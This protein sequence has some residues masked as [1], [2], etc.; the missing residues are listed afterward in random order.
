[1]IKAYVLGS[2]N[3]DFAY[4]VKRLPKIGETLKA[5]SLKTSTGGK[6]AN[7]AV[8]IARNDIETTLI[9][10]VGED[11]EDIIKELDGYGLN[12][13][14]IKKI[15]NKPT[16]SATILLTESSNSIVTDCGANSSV[17]ILDIVDALEDA[18][19]GDYFICQLE[20]NVEIV[21]F[22]LKLAK[23][24]GLVTF[25]NPSPAHDLPTSM[26]KYVDYL[27]LNEVEVEQLSLEKPFTDIGINNIYNFFTGYGVKNI[28]ITLGSEGAW[29]L[30]GED[31]YT[32]PAKD[33]FVIDTT[34]AGDAF[35]GGFVAALAN[36]IPLQESIVYANYAA[37]L[38]CQV[39]GALDSMPKK[40]YI[41]GLINKDRMQ[42]EKIELAR[43]TLKH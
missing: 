37:A 40:A 32:M 13:N 18:I 16:G 42:D 3:K 30:D 27:I 17:G 24:K 11:D 7:Q 22:G 33:T 39:E 35:L 15:R 34:G 12:T 1:M 10:C 29:Y 6:G 26:Y 14:F 9:A 2:I 28:I 21:K 38:A 43:E 8:A 23:D 19:Q 25:L 36:D 5:E 20:V 4:S 31:I 41:M